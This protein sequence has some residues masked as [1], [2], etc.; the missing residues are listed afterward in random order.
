MVF[1]NFILFMNR[2][3]LFSSFINNASG[4]PK[5][6]TLEEEKMYFS[7]F[8]SGDKKAK[9]ILINHNLRLVAHIVKKYSGAGEA[10]DLLSVGSIGLIK[11]INTFE[12]GKGTQLST[13]AARCIENEI[14]MLIRVNKKHKKVISLQENLGQDK[15]GNEVELLEIIPSL[16]DEIYGIVE[17]NIVTEKICKLIDS[18]LSKREAD[19]LKMRY[20]IGGI[21]ALTQREVAVKLGIS[22]SYISRLETKALATIK[23]HLKNIND[24]A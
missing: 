19:I 14:L 11:A 24:D 23:E 15:D 20:G 5:P 6:L 21:P 8:K 7:K 13:Y 2:I 18:T 1:E 17:N 4:F 16:D 9:D 10:D 3:L 12:Y 22:R